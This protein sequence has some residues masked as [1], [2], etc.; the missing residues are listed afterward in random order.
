MD[1]A[2][3]RAGSRGVKQGSQT[4]QILIVLA[5]LGAWLALQLWIL[6]KFG[7]ST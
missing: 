3:E 2:V 6:P 5:I 1:D 7:V 4:M